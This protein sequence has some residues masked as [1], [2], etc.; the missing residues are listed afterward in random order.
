MDI[1][2]ATQSMSETK[3]RFFQNKWINKFDKPLARLWESER[4][5]KWNQIWKT[6]HYNCHQIIQGIIRNCMPT[7]LKIQNK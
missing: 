3:T 6:K 5:L 1:K 2:R 4:I 7:S